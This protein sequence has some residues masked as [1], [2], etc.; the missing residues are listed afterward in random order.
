MTL[1]ERAFPTIA[2]RRAQ[3]R[4]AI[5][6]T[7]AHRKAM[8]AVEASIPV[9]ARDRDEGKWTTASGSDR[10]PLDYSAQDI[11]T[12]QE[13]ALEMSYTPGGHRQGDGRLCA[14]RE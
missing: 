6:E 5:A 13:Q 3:T 12:M 7:V 10:E 2:L 1:L 4:A 9:F 11:T 8:Q 14:G